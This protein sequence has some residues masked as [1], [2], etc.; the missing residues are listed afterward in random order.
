MYVGLLHIHSVLR[1]IILFVSIIVLIK[2]YLGWFGSKNWA[3][4]DNTLGIVFTTVFDMQLLVGLILYFFVSPFTQAAFSDFGSAMKNPELRFYA[5]EHLS[6][7]LIA[8]VLVHVGRAK[9]KKAKADKLKFRIATI[10]FSI[11]MLLVLAGIPWAR[12]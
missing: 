4:L 7:M 10:Y 1:W 3:K 12:L 9:S 2:Y 5:V 8:L 11:A 6:L